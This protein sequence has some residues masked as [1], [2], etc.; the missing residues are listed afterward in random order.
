M[1]QRLASCYTKP[2]AI[3][4]FIVFY[5]NCISPL[6]AS[7]KTN[8]EDRMFLSY[9][10]QQKKVLLGGSQPVF[11]GEENKIM[12][13]IRPYSSNINDQVLNRNDKT[14]FIGGP[15][16]PEMSSFKSAGTSN[17]VNLFT[18]DFSYNIPLLDVDGYPVN[19][20]YNSGIGMEQEA[21]WVGLG[22]NINPGTITRNMRGVPDDF[23][24]SEQMVQEQ[25]IKENNTWGGKLGSDVEVIGIKNLLGL[26]IGN[27][28]G[29]SINNYLG[30]EIELGLSAGV[31]FKLANLA[32]SDKTVNNATL[33]TRLGASASLSS[34][35]GLTINPNISLSSRISSAVGTYNAGVGVT[36]SYNSRTGIKSLQLYEQ[37]SMSYSTRKEVAGVAP[38]GKPYS[39]IDTKEK[40]GF[41]NALRGTSIS[42][43]K[44]S[45]VPAIRMPITNS[46]WATQFEMGLGMF[47]ITGSGRIEVY[48]QKS[49][50][51]ASDRVQRK[52]MVGYMY[53]HKAM[54]NRDAIMDF[55]RFND[56][57]VTPKTPVISVPQYAYD[58]FT[59]SGEGTGGTIRAYRTDHGYVRDNKTRSKDNSFSLGVDI[60]VPGHVGANFNMVKTPATSGDWEDGN[61]LRVANAFKDDGDLL[62]ER[63]YFKN[64]GEISVIDAGQFN[65]IGGLDLVRYKLG[66][67]AAKPVVL[68]VLER[69]HEDGRDKGLVD[70]PA[71]VQ[72]DERKKRTQVINVLTA[73]EATVTGLEQYLKSYS[74]TPTDANLAGDTLAYTVKSRME[75]EVGKKPHHISEID[76]LETDGKRYV[77]GLPVYNIVQ[78]D[79]VFTVSGAA[80]ENDLVNVTEAESFYNRG[81]PDNRDGYVLNSITPAYAHSFLLTGLMS[82]DYVDVTGNGISEDD[83]GTAVKYN[84]TKSES[85]YKWRTP[86]SVTGVKGHFNGGKLTEEKDDKALVSY[87][88]RESWYLHSIESKTMLA[89]FTIENRNDAKGVLSEFEGINAS[90]NS[91]KRLKKIDLYNKSDIR[92]NGLANAKPVKTV[93]FEYDYSLCSNAPGYAG[94]V[95]PHMGKLTLKEIYFTYNGQTRASKN[96]YVFQYDNSPGYQVNA[97][98]RWGNYKPKSQNPQGLKN[99]IHPYAKQEQVAAN[100]NASAWN[101]SK[102][103]LPSGGQLEVDYESDDYA[104]VQDRRATVMMPISNFGRD[105]IKTA[106]RLYDLPSRFKVD[107][108]DKVYLT[109]PV[110]CANA[111]EVYQK[112]LL[113]IEQLAFKLAV[114]MPKGLEYITMYAYIESFGIGDDNNTIWIQ[115]K[116]VD[117][118]SPLSLTAIEHLRE[119]LPGQAFKSYESSPTDSKFAQLLSTINGML[120]E[121]D[122]AFENPVKFL[123][124]EGKAQTVDLS[125][126]FVRLNNPTGIKYGG[127]HRVKA[128]RLKDN[129]KAM[130]NQYTSVYGQKYEYTTT[131]VFNGI[132]RTISSGV[133]SYEPS[134]GGEENPFQEM[135]QIA[136]RIPLGP[137]SYESIEM[138]VLDAFF[139]S[140]LVGYS[141]VTVRSIKSGQLSP[142]NEQ[143]TRSGTGR[144][145]TEFFTAKDF[146]VKYSYTNIDPTSDMQKH[147]ASK[148][149]FFQKWSFDSRAI[150]QGFKVEINDMHGKM[151]SQSTYGDVDAETRISYTENYYRNTGEKGFDEKFDFVYKDLG[152]EIMPGN[153]GIE[154]ELMTDTRQ[155]S[156]NS[157]S[158]NIQAQVDWML[159]GP[160]P[161]W[162]PF[163][164]PVVA[165]SENHYRAVTVAKV[166]NYHSILDSTVVIDKGS[167]I[168]SRNIIFDS[169]T[170][171][172]IVTRTNNAF[173]KPVY[174]T[175]YP[176]WWAYSGMGLAYKNI[177][178]VFRNVTLTEGK[179]TDGIEAHKLKDYFESGDELLISGGET[180]LSA[181]S[182][183]F[184][185]S[186]SNRIWVMDK[187]KNTSSLSNVTPDFIFIDEKGVPYSRNNV[188][189]K[190]VRSGKRNILTAPLADFTSLSSPESLVN[191]T[192][193]LT[194]DY[195]LNKKVLSAS[196]VVYRE[197]W[198]VDRDI[199]KKF[200]EVDVPAKPQGDNIIVNGDFSNGNTGFSSDYSYYPSN[201]TTGGEGR[202]S[203]RTS[204]GGWFSGVSSC[205]DHTSGSGNM[206]VANGHL[207]TGRAVWRQTVAVEPNKE[208]ELLLYAQ[209]VNTSNSPKLRVS[210]NGVQVGPLLT[211]GNSACFWNFLTG[212]W[213]SGNATTAQIEIYNTTL[214]A[215]GNDFA[216]DDI[217]FYSLAE[218][219]CKKEEVEDCNG[220]F[221]KSINPYRKG[222]LG[223]FRANRNMVFYG[224][225]IQTQTTIASAT[226]LSTD[227]ALKE[228]VS[229]WNFNSYHNLIPSTSYKWVW[230]NEI[231]RINSHG[232]ELETKNALGIY[233]SAQYGYAKNIPMA[234]T[235]NSRFEHQ[236][237]ESFE[238]VAYTESINNAT[239]IYCPDYRNSL[240]DKAA[241]TFAETAGI[242]AHSGKNVFK[243]NPSVSYNKTIGIRHN[244]ADFALEYETNTASTLVNIGGNITGT[245]VIPSSLTPYPAPY[246]DGV[247]GMSMHLGHISLPATYA[248]V[249]P[250]YPSQYIYAASGTYNVNGEQYIKIS[251]DDIYSFE[252]EINNQIGHNISY[253]ETSF[254]PEDFAVSAIWDIDLGYGATVN[255]NIDAGFTIYD[256]DMNIVPANL[257]YMRTEGHLAKFYGRVCL[258]PGIYKVKSSVQNF[259]SQ[260]MVTS[261]MGPY[262]GDMPPAII[263]LKLPF[264]D[265]LPVF[266][267]L[268]AST[269]TYDKPIEGKDEMLNANFAIPLGEKMLFS[270]WVNAQD[271]GE[272]RVEIYSDDPSADIV[273]IYPDGPSIDGWKKIEG[274]FTIPTGATQ[275]YF[276][277]LNSH[278][279]PGYLDDIRIHPFNA[280]MTTYVYDPVNLRLTAQLDANNYAT[281]FEYDEEGGLVRKKLETIEGVKTIEETRSAKQKNITTIQ[282]Q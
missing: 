224:D 209:S 254:M 32:G 132:T 272:I 137:A 207:V 270:A 72:V 128:I 206:L 147:E 44:P 25:A 143:K 112:Y 130:T 83:L 131:E 116:K 185:P 240:F 226:K 215:A 278:H 231:T 247:E 77:Y 196:A 108:N 276:S 75:D 84:Y 150:S 50:I 52:P 49:E 19:I 15:T 218:P 98:D 55:S 259:A 268:T 9:I 256:A 121:M 67:D 62:N 168:R 11:F 106:N 234:I 170:G 191:E 267:N 138:P 60:A 158:L 227:G 74:P 61:L 176:A 113:G 232:M 249:S 266:K 222:L 190:I 188:S 189:I 162:M 261:S 269:C 96:K 10:S 87:G 228:F 253:L 40:G 14:F 152:G 255:Q 205:N 212:R 155:F 136:N 164:W 12:K 124:G 39:F 118:Y 109:V 71:V 59:I 241:I 144:Q 99:S 139:P 4:L 148:F 91:N 233:T 3:W 237:Y 198:Q 28:F 265:P 5:L 117:G 27:E 192:R 22:W 262:V 208:Y 107:D 23:N 17:M 169:E 146:P 31:S 171:G 167:A 133:A 200:V 97:T 173:E 110:A 217:S 86:Y 236:L 159:P 115:L 122:G 153:L 179:I 33:Q 38:D 182:E 260:S 177:N 251:K 26:S 70:M 125:R 64:P 119:H 88:E 111:N 58:V 142:R 85:T 16:Q 68:P 194:F 263:K 279:E 140:P 105:N 280:N 100:E 102:I 41:S 229:F 202:Y 243:L 135:L 193:K 281:Y 69:F 203:I 219:A 174:Q 220:Y 79:Y 53:A 134:I 8:L 42:F 172:V 239:G 76:V 274:I 35:N 257:S 197:K 46:A 30:P 246:I 149:E 90:D 165:S 114:H 271:F 81:F 66:G 151:K 36:T 18:G 273:E 94:D 245:Q 258:K 82:P 101:L 201:Y 48:R 282:N 126:S 161:F 235:N 95:G 204:S 43:N 275:I 186:G 29:V 120:Q 2:I 89:L 183:N 37:T 242:K 223:N 65:K 216:I 24:G 6:Y 213:L 123:R 57:E 277:V 141:K 45:Y 92:K 252:L 156:V 13:G 21:S 230:N 187:N 34:R 195:A 248:G 221:E 129:W 211:L 127:G 104:F 166:I 154:V 244:P 199:I 214:I 163:I 73:E 20:F 145:V 93:W 180:P 47:G 56:K 264:T 157:N 63:V 80:D 225:R 175:N 51:A 103:L 54:G 184:L 78:K 210:I 238:D 250:Y 178:G 181:C 1:I 7:A 160:F